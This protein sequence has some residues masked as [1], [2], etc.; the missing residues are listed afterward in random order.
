M[1]QILW[2]LAVCILFQ[3]LVIC[4]LW[5]FCDVSSWCFGIAHWTVWCG[6]VQQSRRIC[7]PGWFL[8]FN[9]SLYI[10][11]KCTGQLLLVNVDFFPWTTLQV[12]FV[13]LELGTTLVISFVM[14]PFSLFLSSSLSV[15]LLKKLHFPAS[16]IFYVLINKV[17]F[18][19]FA[20]SSEAH[21]HT[22]DSQT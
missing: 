16:N 15:N 2:M 5:A 3:L 20:Y 1:K 19:T 7:Q 22:L 8:I 17:T 21:L 11:A 10:S 4:S 18:L 9:C 12:L 13:F 6:S 14:F